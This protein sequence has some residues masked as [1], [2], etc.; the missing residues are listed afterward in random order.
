MHLG[1]AKLINEFI[2]EYLDR[3]NNRDRGDGPNPDHS[4]SADAAN[5]GRGE[6]LN[7]IAEVSAHN[8][9]TK[10]AALRSQNN[11]QVN[12]SSGLLS[13]QP[14]SRPQPLEQVDQDDDENQDSAIQDQAFQNQFK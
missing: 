8:E 10:E 3:R 12:Q 6:Q 5:L 2:I 11:S 13:G 9:I 4:R 7:P 1:S 14:P